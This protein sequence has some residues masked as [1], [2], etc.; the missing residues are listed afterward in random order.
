MW[1]CT[2]APWSRFS[3]TFSAI[4]S[5]SSGTASE[6]TPARRSELRQNPGPALAAGRGVHSGR[7]RRRPV[8]KTGRHHLAQSLPD[9]RDA[10]R[11][12]RLMWM[13]ERRARGNKSIEHGRAGATASRS[14]LRK[15][16]LVIPGTSRSGITITVGLFPRPEPRNRGAVLVPAFDARH[17]RRGAQ[18][19]SGTSTRRAAFRTTCGFPFA[20]GIGR[21]RRARRAGDRV[22]PA[23]PAPQQPDAVR[24]LSH[25]FWHNSNRSG[26]IFPLHGAE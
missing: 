3:F 26:C 1:R 17:R 5:R 19:S 6:S 18:K 16:W 23:L 13:A 12:R 20:V 9:R 21:Q 11:H 25:R 2:P 15:R 4:G 7:H 22:L 8:R 14:A 10:D 24:V